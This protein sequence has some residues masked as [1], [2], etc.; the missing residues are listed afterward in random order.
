MAYSSP[1]EKHPGFDADP[2]LR[3]YINYRNVLKSLHF[4]A[5]TECQPNGLPNAQEKSAGHMGSCV[6]LIH[7]GQVPQC[8]QTRRIGVLLAAFKLLPQEHQY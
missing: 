8:M 3:D 2:L 1:D 5:V 6:V 7:W 4:R